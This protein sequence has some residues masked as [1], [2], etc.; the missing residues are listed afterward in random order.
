MFFGAACASAPV[1]V[2]YEDP[3]SAQPLTTNFTFSDLNTIA[4]AMVD[5]MLSHPA[6][7][8]MTAKRRPLIVISDVMNETDQHV[9]TKSITDTIR[10]QVLRSGKFRFTDID[11]RRKRA[12]ELEYQHESGM[13]K[14]STA[15]ARGQ[16]IG[17]EYMVTGRLVSYVVRTNRIIR[18]DYKFTMELHNI[19][20]G[21]IEWANEKPLSKQQKRPM[22]GL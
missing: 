12:E 8:E 19:Q 3:G 6:T 7:V 22:V 20:T 16:E 14:E 13:V 9:D 4:S 10:T 18:K 11:T 15:A 2:T 5:D 1:T 21:V 17:A